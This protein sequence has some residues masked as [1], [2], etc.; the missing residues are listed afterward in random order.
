[1]GN[2][3]SRTAKA[4]IS[5]SLA[6]LSKWNKKDVEKMLLRSKNELSDY[7]ALNLV[8][9]EV[10]M[11]KDSVG[12]FAIR[13]LFENTFVIKGRGIADKFEVLSVSILASSLTS[14][15]KVEF[16]FDVFNFNDKGYLLASELSLL[17]L[18]AING[19]NRVD[20]SIKTPSEKFIDILVSHAMTNYATSVDH[21]R[22]PELVKFSSDMQ[23]IRYFLD[24]WSGHAGQVLLSTGEQWR[25]FAFP[26]TEIS[27]TPSSDWYSLGFP[28]HFFVRWRRKE[29]IE[30]ITKQ[31]PVFTH[32][33]SMMK[34]QDR[35]IQYHGH[36]I[37]ANGII[38]RGM[39]ADKW[40]LNA[41][42]IVTAKPN[43]FIH[44]FPTT[45]QENAGRYALRIF[46]SQGWR[47][48]FFDDRIP[49]TV[50]GVPLFSHSSDPYESCILLV[51][52]GLAKYFGSYGHLGICGSRS[53]APL[54]GLRLLTGG[55]ILRYF[56]SNFD[57]RSVESDC[58][59]ANGMAAIDTFFDEGSLVAFGLSEYC[60][61]SITTLSKSPSRRPPHGYFFPMV[62]KQIIEGYRYLI[63]KDP[64]GV[65][66]DYITNGYPEDISGHCRTFRIKVEDIPTQFDTIV[67]SRFPDFGRL[68]KDGRVKLPPW[69]SEFLRQP[70]FGVKK[71]AV[72]ILRV[73]DRD[74][75]IDEITK[76]NHFNLAKM[77]REE[78]DYQ[79]SLKRKGHDRVIERTKSL[80]S[81]KESSRS[82]VEKAINL[83]QF[84]EIDDTVD[85][86]FTISR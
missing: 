2:R 74:Y 18:S 42:A 82:K 79:S 65:V 21:I 43:L 50:N 73:F 26:A 14:I 55:H 5:P 6:I 15:E 44:C 33:I 80:K 41:I 72:F 30:P 67:V 78:E 59:G 68:E 38:R 71:P 8:E 32:S 23:D 48:I 19:C 37:V 9:F 60:L 31:R 10:L 57:W 61:Y 20:H 25:D 3:G 24:A 7:F 75:R 69:H 4:R 12:F 66:F 53:D 77:L 29:N 70:T 45:G 36:G 76:E 40:I 52:K 86:S 47:T 39:L 58:V 85:I 83:S 1:M 28:P 17:I 56:V 84:S 54:M 49:C 62:G 16:L 13:D 22:R 11:G 35:R 34:T 46:E 51:E 63:L 81:L 64:W 27:V